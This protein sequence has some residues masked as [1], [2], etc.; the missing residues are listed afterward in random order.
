MSSNNKGGR[1]PVH[2]NILKI[3]VAREYLSSDLGYMKLAIKYGLPG[4]STVRHFVKWYKANYPTGEIP[5]V[6]PTQQSQQPATTSEVEEL[7]KQLQQ[8]NLKVAAWEML[9]E[10]AGKELGVDIVKK[11]GTKQSGK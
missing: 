5:P 1:D 8:A 2:D 4:P 6:Q 7:R 3:A 10:N 9:L 11:F